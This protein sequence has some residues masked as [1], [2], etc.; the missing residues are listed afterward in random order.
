MIFCSR[1]RIF[2]HPASSLLFPCRFA[3]AQSVTVKI[4]SAPLTVVVVWAPLYRLH[5][6]NL[7]RGW[8]IMLGH[9]G[10]RVQELDCSEDKGGPPPL[11]S[12]QRS[13]R[14]Y[15]SHLNTEYRVCVCVWGV[16]RAPVS[17]VEAERAL[18]GCACWFWSR[19]WWCWITV[20]ELAKCQRVRRKFWFAPNRFAKQI[21][22]L[23]ALLWGSPRCWGKSSKGS[24]LSRIS[25]CSPP[26]PL[27]APPEWSCWLQPVVSAGCW[28]S[29]SPLWV[30]LETGSLTPGDKVLKNIAREQE[31]VISIKDVEERQWCWRSPNVWMVS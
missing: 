1:M 14:P 2:I 8:G 11:C 20:S 10:V 31:C 22:S 3:Y 7:S 6:F 25:T 29:N 16:M 4:F 26:P 17:S 15:R 19:H 12:T 23:V 13:L 18:T 5:G 28:M 21:L 27:L 30:Q 24:G 9:R